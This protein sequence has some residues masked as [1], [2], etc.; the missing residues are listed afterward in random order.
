MRPEVR[1]T[2]SPCAISRWKEM[3]SD[4]WL[5]HCLEVFRLPASPFAHLGCPRLAILFNGSH[6]QWP[7]SDFSKI[8]LPLTQRTNS[9]GPR[10][11]THPGPVQEGLVWPSL[12]S[13][14]SEMLSR[15]TSVTIL[16]PF[17]VRTRIRNRGPSDLIAGSD[18]PELQ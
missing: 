10:K 14:H 1:P 13:R 18:L 11:N 4:P 5:S 16:N 17:I 2:F 12:R 3:P 9:P 8:L 6:G 15:R 7:Q